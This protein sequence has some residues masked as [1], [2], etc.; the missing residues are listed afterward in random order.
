M[1][2]LAGAS[3]APS[4]GDRRHLGDDRVVRT[5][6]RVRQKKGGRRLFAPPHLVSLICAYAG[7]PTGVP[8]SPSVSSPAAR[9]WVRTE[10]SAR[11]GTVKPATMNP[12]I[13]V[14]TVALR[15]STPQA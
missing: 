1:A 7:G 15:M 13:H 10:N 6:Q 9:W 2:A 12:V 11:H 5:G 8:G 4:T 14:P 3:V